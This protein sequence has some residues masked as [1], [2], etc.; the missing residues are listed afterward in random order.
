MLC[1]AIVTN[2]QLKE[3]KIIETENCYFCGIGKETIEHLFCD[4]EKVAELWNYVKTIIN[5]TELKQE[6]ILL[7]TITTNPRLL[8]NCLVLL[9]K[10][11][12]YRTRCL[13]GNLDVNALRNYFVEYRNTEFA[14][15]KRKDKVSLHNIKWQ[16]VKL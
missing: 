4:C 14:I 7:N 12:I 2:I 5:L 11:Y 8:A 6:E 10:Y 16:D 13:Q 3:W 9:T 1:R 15:A